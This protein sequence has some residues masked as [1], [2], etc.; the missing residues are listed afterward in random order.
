MQGHG[1]P[2]NCMVHKVKFIAMQ[3]RIERF[4]CTLSFWTSFLVV[5]L[6]ILGRSRVE[7]ISLGAL[8]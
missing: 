4:S 3:L 1:V 7:G 5:S 8:W 2:P 6:L